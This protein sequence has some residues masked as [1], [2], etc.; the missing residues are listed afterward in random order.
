MGL[1]RWVGDDRGVASVFA[2]TVMGVWFGL[3][4]VGVQAGEAVV[5]RHRAA[6]AADLG[7]V[8][9]AGYLVAGVGVACGKAEE[10]VGR[11]GGRVTRCE[12]D[13]WEVSVSVSG[14]PSLFGAPSA[15][16]RAG[17]AEG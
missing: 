17:P 16:A 3:V 12:V 9:A 2:V 13:G 8:A 14:E 6:A 15:R 11:M 4:V 7:A 1:E 5:A 10:V